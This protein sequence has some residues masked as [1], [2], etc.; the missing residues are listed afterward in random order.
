[1]ARSEMKTDWMGNKFTQHY[2]DN[3]N[4]IGRSE[5]K[6]DWTG[7]KFI[8]HYDEKGNETGRSEYKEDWLG[9]KYTQHY[10]EKGEETGHSEGEEGWL[11]DK[12]T[13][14]YDSDGNERARTESKEDWLGNKYKE[15]TGNTSRNSDSQPYSPTNDGDS[16]GCLV[17]LIAYGLVA[18]AVVWFV[19]SV[20]VPLIMINIAAIGLIAGLSKRDWNKYLFPLSFL[21]AIYIVLDINKG[22]ATKELV[23]NV[24]FFKGAIQFFFYL[25]IT[26]GL[27]AAYFLIR[28][29][30]NQKRSPAEG[31]GEFSKRNLIVI[32]CLI[33]L[34]GL[35]IVGQKYFD[36]HQLVQM[37]I[38]LQSAE[39]GTSA[40]VQTKQG[41]KL[42]LKATPSE[43]AAIVAN[44]PNG[45]AISILRYADQFTTVAGEKG[46]WC[47]VNYNGMIGWAWGGFLKLGDNDD[48]LPGD[49]GI[50]YNLEQNKVRSNPQKKSYTGKVGNSDAQY[51]LVWNSDG[52]IDGI[53]HNP[54]KPNVTYLLKGKDWGN[55]KVLLTE[56]TGDAV[57]ANCE[58]LLQNNCYAGTMNN[59]DGRVLQMTMCL[60]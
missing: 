13:Q 47:Q 28:N 48:Y 8:Q 23:T 43:Q 6:E 51:E 12:Y 2:G 29:Y 60:N 53:Y 40:F 33:L 45:A 57:S 25:N 36:A 37:D 56:F 1:M 49:G 21:G 18:A 19:F 7:D 58:L 59:T 54:K 27:V 11:G 10:D 5:E 4:E 52:T 17:K 50:D 16:E 44:I 39:S 34:G 38:P 31:E 30:L 3:G 22:W 24:S 41:S 46:K 55:G 9:D 26:A 14:H 42:R 15:T 20:A 35:T 32:G